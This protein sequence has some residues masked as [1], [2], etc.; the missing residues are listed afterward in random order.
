MN[1]RLISI[2]LTGFIVLGAAL[3]IAPK[4]ARA[5]SPAQTTP[6]ALTDNNVVVVYNDNV[7]L[8]VIWDKD[9]NQRVAINLKSGQ[10]APYCPCGSVGTQNGLIGEYPS[11]DGSTLIF[12]D[13]AFN[14]RIVLTNNG[15]TV[16]CQCQ[17]P[18]CQK[19]SNPSTST[20]NVPVVGKTTPVP[21]NT[22]VPSIKTSTPPPQPTRT[23][24]PTST[25]VPPTGTPVPPPTDTPAAKFGT[26]ITHYD[27]KGNVVFSK[28][29]PDS[30]VN[31]HR[32]HPGHIKQ[33][34]IGPA[35]GC[36][37]H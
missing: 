9:R 10:E 18:N 35:D 36:V 22:P 2:M 28:C 14:E 25:H 13:L 34:Y 11:V 26:W 29:M 30:A 32:N 23:P 27:A 21:T 4:I 6:V 19:E 1:K 15:I 37:L 31:G 20:P 24:V 7:N 12:E 3:L 5:G 8:E 16:Y 17:G 33:D